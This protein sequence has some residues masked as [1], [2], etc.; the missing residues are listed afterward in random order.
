MKSRA[1]TPELPALV[2][3]LVVWV[4]FAL[5][6]GAPFRS[7]DGT[8]SY[9]NAAA[10]VGILAVA[11]T[12]LMIAGEFDLSIG[13]TIGLCSMTLMLLTAHYGWTLWAALPVTILVAASIGLLNGI[14]V[15]KSGLPSFLVTLATLFIARG[16]TIAITRLVTGRTQ[17]GG[18]ERVAGFE[19]AREFF[20]RDL[21]GGIRVSVLWWAV[22]VASG[23][24]VLARTRFGN[25]TT[26]VGGAPGAARA[27]GVPVARVKLT[28]FVCT[29]LA[30]CLVAVLQ[31]VRFTGADALRGEAQEL[32][33]IVAVV[34]GGTLLSGGHGSVLG[35]AAG[36]LI[37]GMLQQ[38]IVLTGASADWFQVLLGALLLV[39]VLVNHTF[40]IRLLGPR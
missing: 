1:W 17:L 34:L 29:A 2:G 15:V 39:A 26:A 35:A 8:A 9:L 30:A 20:G 6:A 31:T 12:L 13:S 14:V 28:L 5:S 40:L 25:W 7:A 10:P 27:M 3:V 19:V 22:L 32:R 37:F 18:L 21:A 23:A 24:W 11:V 33:A 16:L 4:I 38:G 36:A